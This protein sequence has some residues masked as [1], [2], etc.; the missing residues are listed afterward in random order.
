M[1]SIEVL[2]HVP[3]LSSDNLQHFDI[4]YCRQIFCDFGEKF[5][6]SDVTGEQPLSVMISAITKVREREGGR[7]EGG[8]Q[9]ERGIERGSGERSKEGMD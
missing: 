5:L 2:V 3:F 1:V 6:V 8:G 9:K 7:E 4:F